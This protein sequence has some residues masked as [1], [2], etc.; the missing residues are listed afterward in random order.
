MQFITQIPGKPRKI[1]IAESMQEA[2]NIA[3][4]DGDAAA[5]VIA[6]RDWPFPVSVNADR[7]PPVVLVGEA[8]L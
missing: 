4:Q 2:A 1:T 3:E 7:V 6:L 8:L 5:Q